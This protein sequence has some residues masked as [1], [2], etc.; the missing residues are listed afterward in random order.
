M[1]Q[2]SLTA[3]DVP[4]SIGF[5]GN[6]RRAAVFVGVDDATASTTNLGSGSV[7]VLYKDAAGDWHLYQGTGQ[8]L[9]GLK[10]GEQMVYEAVDMELGV[11][12]HGSSASGNAPVLV[13]VGIGE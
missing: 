2:L 5:A 4:R 10:A 12:L 9:T 8:A 11:Q 7:Q 6:R 1:K 3:N 13:N